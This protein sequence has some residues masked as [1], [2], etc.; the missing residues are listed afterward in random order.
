MYEGVLFALFIRSRGFSDRTALRVGS[1]W[2]CTG[3]VVQVALYRIRLK[4][5]LILGTVA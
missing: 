1:A 2:R 5:V 3:D 4:S